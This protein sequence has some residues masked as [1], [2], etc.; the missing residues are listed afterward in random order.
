MFRRVRVAAYRA[1]GF[2]GTP[3]HAYAYSYRDQTAIGLALETF[4]AVF[5]CYYGYIATHLLYPVPGPDSPVFRKR[6]SKVALVSLPIYGELV[7]L[8]GGTPLLL[9]TIL[10]WA[11][12]NLISERSCG[13][14]KAV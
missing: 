10:S 4:A 3:C 5:S 1:R 2:T 8:N 9:L 7:V 13:S 6:G 14:P 12:S 11:L